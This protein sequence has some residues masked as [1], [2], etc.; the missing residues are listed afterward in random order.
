MAWCGGAAKILATLF[1]HGTI[2]ERRHEPGMIGAG[3]LPSLLAGRLH[4][5]GGC[6][7]LR[8]VGPMVRAVPMA[9]YRAIIESNR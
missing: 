6:A 9:Q 3:Y 7:G 2:N 1:A 8:P 4:S 5:A